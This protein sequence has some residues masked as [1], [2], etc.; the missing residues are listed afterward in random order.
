[1][2]KIKK[3]ELQL[4][5]RIG[6]GRF[7]DVYEASHPT[8]KHKL[9]LKITEPDDDR[10][11]HN[12]RNEL[13]ILMKLLNHTDHGGK[14]KYC[15]NVVRLLAWFQDSIE[16]GFVFPLYQY[17]LNKVM[18]IY[19]STKSAFMPDGSIQR[20][21]KN[22]LKESQIEQ[23]FVGLLKG[24]QFIHSN[25]IIHRDINPN[26]IMFDSLETI[27]PIIIDFGISYDLPNNHGL[28]SPTEKITDVATS[29]YKA[30][31]L[32]MS[33]RNYSDKVDIWSLGVILMLLSSRN[34]KLPYDEDAQHSD[35]A[36]ISSIFNTF[37]SPS[38]DWQEVKSSRSFQAMNT[39]FF[40]K[41]PKPLS[42]ILPLITNPALIDVFKKM[43]V[44]ESSERISASDALQK[45]TTA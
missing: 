9:A 24:L 15:G 14:Q 36:L 13:K 19:S 7:S 20:I 25:E 42:V 22:T 35:L 32:L 45:I 30:P 1:M 39:N 43:M 26:N 37:G 16:I 12:S 5:N 34:G 44:F 3:S 41:D 21:S 10:P 23:I 38:E 27:E 28:E 4:G 40:K 18:K 33:V 2:E 6:G 17:D 31:E 29:Y 11:P 8:I